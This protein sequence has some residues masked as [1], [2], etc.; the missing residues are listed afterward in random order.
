MHFIDNI[1]EL[2]TQPILNTDTYKTTH[3][4]FAPD[5]LTS[6]YG[7]LE[8][9]K[10]GEFDEV[11]WFG[12]QYIMR[13][14]QGQRVT[15]AMIDETY[16]ELADHGIEMDRKPWVRIVNRY[17]GV[18]PILISSL[19]EGVIVPQGTVLSTFQSD[20]EDLAGIAPYFEAS[21]MRASYPTTIATRSM[22]WW[23]LIKRYLDVSGDPSTADFK[24]VDFGARGAHS[25]ESAAIGGMAH[26][27]NFQVTD[28]LMGIRFAKHAYPWTGMPGFSIPAS[29]HSV[30]TAWGVGM[31]REE[32][33]CR[34]ALVRFG[35]KPNPITGGRNAVSIVNDT[36]D[37]DEHIKMWGTTLKEL[38]INSH[39]TLV[40]RPDSGDPIINVVHVLDL[41]GKYFGWTVNEKGFRVLPEYVRVIQGDGINEETLRRIMQRVVYHKWSLDNLN[42]GSGGGLLVHAAE[43]DTHRFAMKSSE[44]IVGGETRAIQKLVKT[45]PSKASKKGRFAVIREDDKWK[46]IAEEELEGRHNYLQPVFRDGKVVNTRSF[47][48]VREMARA[49]RVSAS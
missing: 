35:S 32:L 8:A 11:M 39:M 20:D 16:G 6:S 14:Y 34:Q 36:T 17:D 27:V 23:R 10:G 15:H 38:L 12:Q 26:L 49:A 45:D 41:L 44:V 46:T 7:Y 4:S 33:L 29:E 42:F 5:E 3:H 19:P 21:N 28:N 37:Q 18:A 1:G 43:R 24:L 22:R 13:Y 48:E 40:T 30:T 9:R 2:L 31:D 25:T 47:A